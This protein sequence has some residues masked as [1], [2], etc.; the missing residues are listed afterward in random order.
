MN[1]NFF[2]VADCEDE[3]IAETLQSH[4]K[5]SKIISL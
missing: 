4:S 1:I 5:P 2:S 3:M